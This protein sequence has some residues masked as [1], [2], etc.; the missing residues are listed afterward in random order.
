MNSECT[1]FSDEGGLAVRSHNLLLRENLQDRAA[2][3]DQKTLPAERYATRVNE[4]WKSAPLR[5]SKDLLWNTLW[6][7]SHRVARFKAKQVF[8]RRRKK[9]LLLLRGNPSRQL[10]VQ[11]ARVPMMSRQPQSCTAGGSECLERG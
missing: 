3:K 6:W 9:D 1:A 7:Y 4:S 5:S 10:Q 11:E 8:F 2:R